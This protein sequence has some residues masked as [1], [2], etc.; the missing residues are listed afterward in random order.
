MKKAQLLLI[1]VIQFLF[2]GH[3]FANDRMWSV[4]SSNV[5]CN[6]TIDIA[7]LVEESARRSLSEYID[8]TLT[9]DSE[10]YKK[11]QRSAFDDFSVSKDDEWKYLMKSVEYRKI[12]TNFAR[13]IVHDKERLISLLEQTPSLGDI[14]H[15]SIPHSPNIGAIIS[16]GTW[17][18]YSLPVAKNHAAFAKARGVS[19]T[20]VVYEQGAKSN[21]SRYLLNK[22]EDKKPYWGKVIL[23]MKALQDKHVPQNKWI[24]WIDDD[25]IIND[26]EQETSQLDRIIDIYGSNQ[27]VL[28]AA[29]VWEYRGRY[30]LNIN[31]TVASLPN[32]GV[33]LLKNTDLCR[34]LVADWY[35][36]SNDPVIG[37]ATQEQTLHEQTAL[38]NLRT[39]KK[40][41]NL[42]FSVANRKNSE[43]LKWAFHTFKRFS[44]AT[45]GADKIYLFDMGIQHNNAAISGDAYIHHSGMITLYRLSLIAHTLKEIKDKYPVKKVRQ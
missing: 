40:Y 15:Q 41:S 12:Y 27:C 43:Q 21:I 18:P 19:Y 3:T 14:D 7:D 16:G 44:H 8:Q 32:T 28:T 5:T 25:I 42:I 24:M 38:A 1:F 34:E 9:R 23:L 13:E 35:D 36:E 11:D 31:G 45:N 6:K 4:C 39:Q 10:L 29:D 33:V 17:Q 2:M 20:Y 37:K 22:L 26:F 30:S